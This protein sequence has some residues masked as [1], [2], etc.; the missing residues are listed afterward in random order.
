MER[1]FQFEG[2][3]CGE[4]VRVTFENKPDLVGILSSVVSGSDD[5]KD[6]FAQTHVLTDP[7]DNEY[8][9]AMIESG[10]DALEKYTFVSITKEPV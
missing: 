2:L 9:S 4:R 7:D 8:T 3:Q 1:Y 10:P 6:Q 5:P